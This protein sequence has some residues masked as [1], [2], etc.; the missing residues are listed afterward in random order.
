MY[1]STLTKVKYTLSI[2]QIYWK[3]YFQSIFD[4]HFKF[5]CSIL[6]IYFKYTSSILQLVKLQNKTFT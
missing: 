6:Q 2:L 4:A 5:T 1:D 3:Y